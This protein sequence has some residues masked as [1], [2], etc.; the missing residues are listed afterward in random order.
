MQ[1]DYPRQTC[2]AGRERCTDMH[3]EVHVKK[4]TESDERRLHERRG[5]DS[6]LH[7]LL[8]CQIHLEMIES[9][10]PCC[11]KSR[12]EP[13]DMVELN[14][15]RRGALVQSD[16]LPTGTRMS[17]IVPVSM[18]TV[19]IVRVTPRP[20]VTD[21]WVQHV[22]A[23]SPHEGPQLH[24][25]SALITGMRLPADCVVHSMLYEDNDGVLVLGLFDLSSLGSRQMQSKPPLERHMR[26]RETVPEQTLALHGRVLL[27]RYLWV[28]C[29]SACLNALS[30]PRTIPNM[31]FE[32]RCI[33]ILPATIGTAPFERKLLPLV[34]PSVPF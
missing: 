23:T 27:V 6:H 3:D 8:G 16:A 22:P 34:L 18:A 15:H 25:A 32:V 19:T 28:G 12:L 26:L 17:M 1:T 24:R 11:F 33:G 5:C 14:K 7:A 29:E 30:D 13:Y 20:G 4:E 9:L 31:S 21:T 10:Y 2:G